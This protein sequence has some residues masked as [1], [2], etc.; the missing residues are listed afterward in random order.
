MISLQHKAV[1]LA[2]WAALV[3]LL[4][5]C[6]FQPMLA[7]SRDQSSVEDN[8]AKIKVATIENRSGQVLRNNLIDTLTPGGEPS[9]PAYTLLIR[10]EEPQQ[11]LAFQRNN[12]VTNVAYSINAYWRLVDQNGSPV[13]ASTS[14]SSQ[15]YTLSNSQYATSVSA[16]NTRD[17]IVQDLTQDIRNQLARYFLSA[18]P[19]TA[20]PQ[21]QR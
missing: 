10:I 5:G 19:T 18:K 3:C 8:F 21:S 16:Q 14:S 11:N 13:Y 4:D 12:S 7:K 15:Q 2:S 20:A 9:H 17:Q 6:G 1:F